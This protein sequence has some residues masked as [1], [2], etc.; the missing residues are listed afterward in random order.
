[1][2]S[3]VFVRPTNL[4]GD[5]ISIRE[6]LYFGV[7]SVASGVVARPREC[8]LFKSRD[9]KDFTLKTKDVLDNY[10]YYKKKLDKVKIEDNAEEVIKVYQK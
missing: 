8:I 3:E 10:K 6:A 2:K 7:P 9:I 1:M 5:A 4:D